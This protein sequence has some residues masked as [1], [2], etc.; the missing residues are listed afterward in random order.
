MRNPMVVPEGARMQWK[1]V[2]RKDF[3]NMP[4]IVGMFF[5][6]QTIVRPIRVRVKHIFIG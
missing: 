1:Q 3:V 6:A 5:I 4:T 2:K